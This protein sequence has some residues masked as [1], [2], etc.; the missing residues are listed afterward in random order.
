MD[1]ITL[2]DVTATFERKPHHHAGVSLLRR[3]EYEVSSFDLLADISAYF[4]FV[5]AFLEDIKV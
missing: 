2:L 3:L 1:G 4:E 5:L